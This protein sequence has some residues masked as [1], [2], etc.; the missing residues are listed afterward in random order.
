MTSPLT[1]REIRRLRKA[2]PENQPDYPGANWPAWV[3]DLIIIASY[4]VWG[5]ICIAIWEWL[6]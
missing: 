5:A 6:T 4:L 1:T 2:F 3:G